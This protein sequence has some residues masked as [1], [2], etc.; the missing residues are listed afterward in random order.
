VRALSFFTQELPYDDGS[1]N[2]RTGV[3]CD[4][5]QANTDP[6]GGAYQTSS[7]YTTGAGPRKLRGTFALAAL[8]SGSI[9][10]IDVDDYDAPCRRPAAVN[11]LETLPS[12]V[13]GCT[14][15]GTTPEALACSQAPTTRPDGT[16]GTSAEYS[17]RVVDRHEVRSASYVSTNSLVGPHAPGFVSF[18]QLQYRGSTL[19]TDQS[20]DGEQNPRMRGPLVDNATAVAFDKGGTAL[21]VEI[22]PYATG[23]M[24]AQAQNFVIADV[25]EPRTAVDQDWSLTY[26][27]VLP[28]FDGKVARLDLSANPPA[29]RDANGYFCANGTHDRDA[30]RVEARRLLKAGAGDSVEVYARALS[31]YVEITNAL[32]DQA[33]PYWSSP[34]LTCSF[35]SCQATFG[36]SDYPNDPRFFKIT[37]AYQDHVEVEAPTI[38]DSIT[39]QTID[40]QCCFPT[41]VSYR[42][43]GG[44]G[45]WIA[46]G[47]QTGFLHHVLADG[48]GKCIV[49]GVV[50]TTGEVCDPTQEVRTGRAYQVLNNAAALKAGT[51]SVDAGLAYPSDSKGEM[52]PRQSNVGEFTFH[53]PQMYLV[54]YPGKQ[55]PKRDMAFTW[56]MGGGF[57]PLV[58]GLGRGSPLVAPQSMFY[59]PILGSSVL[60]T[61]GALQ[62][63]VL[64][65]MYQLAVSNAFF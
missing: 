57:N 61:D 20:T 51:D 53:N 63:V 5:S 4:P 28:G 52:V 26:G 14:E 59:H 44:D 21:T 41:L 3:S 37:K 16:N 42:V 27:G 8:T 24:A 62:G 1:G 17:C 55:A 2:L 64:V 12:W 47:A 19:R 35:N 48:A 10:V 38:T 30:G 36:T 50:P 65:D 23:G 6:N 60:V 58:I 40:T 22:D 7:D 49:G 9:E 33:D 54:V 34:G 15:G 29:V 39:G 32:L 46:V 13:T 11:P 56:H 45:T 31:D 18:P 25:R 43:R